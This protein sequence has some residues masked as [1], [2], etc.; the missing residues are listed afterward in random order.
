MVKKEKPD[1]LFLQET[2][3]ERVDVGICRQLWDSEEFNWVA[4]GSSGAS[5]GLLCMWDRRSFIKKEEFTGDGFVGISG[6]WGVNK[7]QF[8]LVNVYGPNDR[9]KK[10]K[11][12]E[13]LRNMVTDKEGSWLIAGDFNAVRGP[14]EKRGRTGESPDMKDFDEFIVTTDLV[15]VKLMNRNYTWYKSDGTARSRLDRFL[16]NT[17]MSNME[18]EWVQQGLPRNISDHCAIVLKS[19]TTDWGPRPFRVLDAWQQHPDFKKFVE[20]KWSEMEVEGYA[21]YKCQQKLKLLKGFLK[22]WNKEVFGNMETQYEQAVKKIEQVDKQNEISELEEAE[23]V[24]RQE[25]FSEMWECLRKK[26]LIWKQKSRS[27]WVREGDANT[28]FFHRMAK[29]RRAH[30]NIAGLRCN[31][32]WTDDPDM[33]KDE[34][35]RY[36]RRVFQGET[37]NRPKPGNI[38]FQ[39]ISEEKKEWLEK[40]FSV[41]EIE[42]G[43]RS[44]DGSKAPGPDGYNFNFLKF[45]WHCIKEDFIKFFSEFHCNGKLVRGLNSSFIALIPKKLNATELKDYRPISLLGCVYKLLANVLANRLKSMISEVVSDA[46][47]LCGGTSVGG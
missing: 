6:E 36:F 37:W 30:N 39:Q 40:P 18:G 22:D 35:A 21:G 1:F 12:W 28:R 43:L 13:E 45:A 23:I 5:G 29:G 26:E 19:R 16:L 27:R 4:K 10:I 2:K 41:E 8:F 31:G 15:D 20:K 14:E 44:C 24:K 34:I 11:L 38:K 47:C 42:E 7:Q 17:E 3:I 25:G 32:A 46:I 33:V 9:Q